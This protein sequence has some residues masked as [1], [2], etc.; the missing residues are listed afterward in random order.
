MK[1]TR[2]FIT[3]FCLG[4]FFSCSKD[5]SEEEVKEVY[6][7]VP[8]SRVT[9]IKATVVE[10]TLV[11]ITWDAATD[12][13]GDSVTYEVIVNN[14]IL[15]ADYLETSVEIDVQ[16]YISNQGNKGKTFKNGVANFAGKS[17]VDVVL[18]IEIRAYDGNGSFSN[19]STIKTLNVNRS[20]NEFEFENI[21]FNFYSYDSIEIFWSL[22]DDP[23][24][25]SIVYTVY[26]NDE[27]ITDDTSVDSYYNRGYYYYNNNFYDLLNEPITIKVVASDGSAQETYIEQVYE[28]RATDIDLGPLD[29]PS[30]TS[31][32]FSIAEEEPDDRIGF[33]F[34][35]TEPSDYRIEANNMDVN[36]RDENG[37]LINSSYHSIN[38]LDLEVGNYYVEV[39]SYYSQSNS[40]V[41]IQLA[42]ANLSDVDLGNVIAPFTESYIF[43]L[44]EEIDNAIIYKFTVEEEIGAII[45]VD[46]YYDLYIRDENGNYVNYSST[47]GGIK[48]PSLF[49]GTTYLVYL[50]SY[51]NQT[52]SGTINFNFKNSEETN[53]DLGQLSTN[54]ILE[55]TFDLSVEPD[56]RITYTIDVAEATGFSFYANTDLN[57]EIISENGNYIN[58]SYSSYGKVYGNF[59]VP[60]KYFISINSYYSNS[61]ILKLAIADPNSTDLDLGELTLPFSQ[62]YNIEFTKSDTDDMLEYTFTIT[63]LA[64][65]YNMS[66][67]YNSY[68]LVLLDQNGNEINYSYYSPMSGS[69]LAPG[70]YTIRLIPNWNS[71]EIDSMTDTLSI[72]LNN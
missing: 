15:V 12:D 67:G 60:G 48:V 17:G 66:V 42:D 36:L 37:N 39:G 27:L 46:N 9:N 33:T 2:L 68:R 24:G 31:Q 53:L 40:T 13:N 8:P 32:E 21:Y 30:I 58:T 38:G 7:N 47:S 29:F 71:Y 26:I 19:E 1:I 45:T 56:S 51:Y 10:G 28:F 54:E 3:L 41:T 16:E 44:S 6:V 4:V 52:D 22:T 25:D 35:I 57:F 18:G 34:S 65:T 61:G 11:N 62:S 50:N 5:D 20:P 43:D 72:T 55:T 64:T 14:E 23:D 49:P 69:S 70:T 59:N 63:E